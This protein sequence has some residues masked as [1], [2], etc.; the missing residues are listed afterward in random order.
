MNWIA[1]SSDLV[2][3]TGAN[4]FVGTYVI[5]SLL[6]HGFRRIRCIVRS[7]RNVADLEK[8]A[9]KSGAQLEFL[10]GSLSSK[11]DCLRAVEGAKLVYHLAVG[12]TG[13]SFPAAVLN[14]VVPTRNL[15]DA[16]VKS[17]HV[18]R[19]VNVSSLAVYSNRNNP[20][21]S[22]LD[23]TG[24]VELRPQ[25]R[26]D[27]YAYAKLKQDQIVADYG[28]RYGLEY[29]MVRPGVV[30]G[31]GKD[32]IPG[33]VGVDTF[34]FFAHLG[35]PNR[36]P[37]TYVANCAEAIVLSGL[38]PGVGGEVFNIIDDDLPS[39]RQFLKQY[40]RHVRKFSSVY[41]PHF[42]SYFFCYVWKKYSDRTKGQLPPVFS[43]AEWHAYWKKTAYSNEKLKKMLGWKMTVPTQEG[44][45][46][47]FDFCR[48]HQNA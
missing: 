40:K 20:T 39:S 44:L 3:V 27:A 8:R 17:G 41:V 46:Y 37:L 48:Q 31:P 15:L 28:R 26:G 10:Q 42:L 19:F 22:L 1:S 16:V 23:E 7:S 12:S 35:G 32:S 29:V 25:D 30:Y 21:G 9:G 4:G 2:L 38:I 11:D 45:R 13:K 34:G 43:P 5:Q 18:R 24:P 6:D 36:I 14:V 47:Y 33:R